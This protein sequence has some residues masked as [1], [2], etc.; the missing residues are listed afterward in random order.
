MGVLRAIG[1]VAQFLAICGTEILDDFP[2]R[3]V[4]DVE[5]AL[6]ACIGEDELL[7]AT[8]QDGV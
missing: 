4:L 8:M 5:L 3:E 7:L 2:R 6:V 1:Y